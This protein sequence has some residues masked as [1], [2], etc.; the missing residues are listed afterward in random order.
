MI[1]GEERILTLAQIKFQKRKKMC[2]AISA[3]V[4]LIHVLAAS[5]KQCTMKGLGMTQYRWDRNKLTYTI[6]T[7]DQL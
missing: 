6:Y 2:R 3:S 5:A 4:L 7:D 1:V